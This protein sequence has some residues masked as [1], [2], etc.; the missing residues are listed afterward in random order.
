MG[1]A[2]KLTA[3]SLG[4]GV[5]STTMA[6]MAK[7]GEIT[8]MPDCAIF[9]D[10]QAEPSGVYRHLYWLADGVLPFP[11]HSVTAGD[12][13]AQIMKSSQGTGRNDGR[14]PFFIKNPDGTRGILNR[15]CTADFKLGPF[16]AKVR[17]LLGLAKGQSIRTLPVVK[18]LGI[19]RKDP[20][21]PFVEQWIGISLDEAQRMK[22]SL[23]TWV[24]NRYPLVE[25]RMTRTD[26]EVW[27]TAHGYK[28]PVKSA[29]TFCPF[30]SDLE[31]IRMRDDDPEAFADAAALD[32]AIRSPGY[33]NLIGEA[34]VHASLKPL[35]QVDFNPTPRPRKWFQDNLWINECEGMCGV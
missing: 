18:A 13:R 27:L 20:V 11:V 24:T 1:M 2:P 21:P 31:W 8:P 5:Q 4:A 30:R 15:Q 7:H 19:K 29:C 12:L 17:A 10:T 25:M 22:P 32:R 33:K 6:L 34:Y 3:I 23:H 35:D 26:C 14:P 28:I 16:H 9:A